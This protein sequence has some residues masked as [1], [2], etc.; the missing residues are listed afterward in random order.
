VH[1]VGFDGVERAAIIT[2]INGNGTIDAVEFFAAGD[3]AHIG[4]SLA[5][6]N[7]SYSLDVTEKNSWHWPE[8]V[9]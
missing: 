1:L 3:C 8:R 9:E 5:I 2:R 6:A 4:A 7:V